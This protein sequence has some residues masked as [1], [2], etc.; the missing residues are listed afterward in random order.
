MG[1]KL[2]DTSHSFPYV[3]RTIR[4]RSRNIA[5]WPFLNRNSRPH[6]PNFLL[7][8]LRSVLAWR[9]V[10]DFEAGTRQMESRGHLWIL[11]AGSSFTETKFLSD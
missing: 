11:G 3:V 9:L 8:R 1:R 5:C 6:L 4:C 2:S 10:Y 7:P